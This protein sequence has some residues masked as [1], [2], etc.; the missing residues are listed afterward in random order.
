MKLSK[1]EEVK[2]RKKEGIERIGNYDGVV[3]GMGNS[4]F[5]E[6]SD[7][8]APRKYLDQL[9]LIERGMRYSLFDGRRNGKRILYATTTAGSSS[10]SFRFERYFAHGPTDR[11]I[12]TGYIGATQ[13]DLEVGDFIIP[14][15]AIIGEGTTPYYFSQDSRVPPVLKRGYTAKPSPQ[16]LDKLIKEAMEEKIE[17]HSGRIYTT[18]SFVM[19][20]P[21]LIDKLNK[22]GVLGI[23]ME[24]S[25]L[26]SIADYHSKN[27][28]AILVVTDNQLTHHTHTLDNFLRGREIASKKLQ[29][30]IEISTKALLR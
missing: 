22:K 6:V 14:E 10:A 19:E 7:V 17:F 24:T 16:I 29:K 23:D 15:E 13:D 27:T 1:E 30:A 20:T 21:Q 8:L 5:E 26:F 25:C 18:D 2:Y 11:S 12:G 28:A 9:S 4:L 3:F